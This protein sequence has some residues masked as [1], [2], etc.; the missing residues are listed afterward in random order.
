MFGCGSPLL[1]T[2]HCRHCGLQIRGCQNTSV[3]RLPT[4]HYQ[5]SGSILGLQGRSL[6][7]FTFSSSLGSTT[8]ELLLWLRRLSNVTLL[9]IHLTTLK[10]INIGRHAF[11]SMAPN[12]GWSFTL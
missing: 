5:M 2:E 12:C 11:P 1:R 3:F 10:G 9:W 6:L 8:L 7:R 4:S